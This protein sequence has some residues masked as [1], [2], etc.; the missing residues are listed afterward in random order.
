MA[1]TVQTPAAADLPQ[2]ADELSSWQTDPW[3]GH[4]HTGDLGWRTLL[5]AEGAAED[6][7]VWARDGSPVAI[8]ML[9]DGV[10]RLALDPE[11]VDDEVVATRIARDL[12]DPRANV[13]EAGEALVEARGAL[14]LRGLLLSD[15]WVDDELWTPFTLDLSN[16]LDSSPFEQAGLRVER[17]GVDDAETWAAVHW[18]AFKG[19]PFEGAPRERFIRRWVAMTSGP[20]AD[21]AHNLIGFD[22]DGLPVAVTT[23]WTA[24]VDE[25]GLIEPM[26]VHPDHHGHGYG[27]AITV[28]GA[29]AL[30][31]SGASSANVVAENSNP[32]AIATYR[33]AGFTALATVADLRRL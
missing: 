12:G 2:I 23:V 3:V 18:A 32:A 30:R 14:A 5:G 31:E 10:L 22:R 19:T 29:D 8:G 21:R 9:D 4:L 26:A 1:F 15:G 20:L 28:A 33:A 6:L 27:R 16:G 7:R 24:G 13:F 25:P 11:L 17:A